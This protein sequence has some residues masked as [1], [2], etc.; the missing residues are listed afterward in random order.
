MLQLKDEWEQSVG[1]QAAALEARMI[2]LAREFIITAQRHI[3][4]GP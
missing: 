3:G 2:E 1:D 4:D